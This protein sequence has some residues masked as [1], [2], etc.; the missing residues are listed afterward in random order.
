MAGSPAGGARRI[1]ASVGVVHL[2]PLAI[3]AA[4]VDVLRGAARHGGTCE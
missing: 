4:D 2:P 1:Q 3:R